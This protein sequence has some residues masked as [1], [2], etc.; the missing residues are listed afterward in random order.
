M[1]LTIEELEMLKELADELEE[2][3]VETEK[4]LQED[5]GEK[6][7]LVHCLKGRV[8]CFKTALQMPKTWKP[9]S[10]H[11]KSETYLHPSTTTR[12]PL[13]NFGN[14]SCSF[15]RLFFSHNSSQ[16]IIDAVPSYFSGNWTPS[17]LRHSLHKQNQRLR[18]LRLPRSCL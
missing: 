5:I 12:A 4:A 10:S 6:L 8:F 18:L 13:I 15:N 3:H 17:V 1:R 2:Q 7:L 11:R 9:K 16:V 14:L